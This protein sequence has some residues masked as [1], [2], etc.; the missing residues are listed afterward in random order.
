M[1]RPDQSHFLAHF[2]KNGQNYHPDAEVENPS[3]DQ[4]S[5]LQRM[6]NILQEKKYLLQP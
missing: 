4:M 5:A 6:I 1:T 3:N 2:T